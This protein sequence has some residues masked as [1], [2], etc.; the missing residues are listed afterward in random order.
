MLPSPAPT[1]ASSTPATPS[2]GSEIL[3]RRGPL[4]VSVLTEDAGNN[5]EPSVSA[6]GSEI[7]F[8][9]DRDGDDELYRAASDGSGP[10]RPTT[11]P[12][13]DGE[14]AFA[15]DDSFAFRTDRHGNAEIYLWA[16]GLPLER[17]TTSPG[18]D[19]EPAVSQDGTQI[20][21][22]SN[23]DGDAEI[24]VIGIDGSTPTRLTTSP[25]FDG[26]PAF[27]PDGSQIAFQ[28][29]RDGDEEIYLMSADGSAQTRLTE[30]PGAD[31]SPAF[32]PE[33]DRV[34][35][36]RNLEGAR[37][38]LSRIGVDGT[39]FARVHT[40]GGPGRDKCVVTKP[41]RRHQLRSCEVVKVR[42]R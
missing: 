9:S 4:R 16:P 8:R 41:R 20:A 34:V 42:R 10:Q 24:Y 36:V 28:S 38:S 25:G 7:I 1:G 22:R 13:F 35:F 12:G 40:D 26:E 5:H 17:L 33:G 21:F 14:P 18:F 15:P 23:R 30:N 31:H 2:V 27:S 6:D 3:S 32:S 29:E 19:G 37:E 39:G 11:S